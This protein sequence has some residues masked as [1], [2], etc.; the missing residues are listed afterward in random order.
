MTDQELR[1]T[2][3]QLHWTQKQA[4]A[5]LGVSQPYLSL[6]ENGLRPVPASFVNR[7]AKHALLPVTSLPLEDKPGFDPQAFAES[8]GALGYR[9]F[10]YLAKSDHRENPAALLLRA[11]RQDELEP[12]LTEALPWLLLSYPKLNWDWLVEHAKR[13]NLQNR[14]GFLVSV[15]RELAENQGAGEP[16]STLARWEHSLE[17]ARL[18]KV[19]VLC[20]RLTS[21]EQ[22]YFQTHRSPRAMHWNLLT[23]LTA[24]TIQYGG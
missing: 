8:L 15:A 12:R 2:R 4:G 22:Q 10:S 3:Q 23:G 20:R 1:E 21:A 24:D 9:R 5:K 7:L 17:D 13:Q 18:A 6:L 19:D 11:L 16:V 14:L